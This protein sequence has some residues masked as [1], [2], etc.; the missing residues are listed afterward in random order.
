LALLNEAATQIAAGQSRAAF[1][2]GVHALKT[3]RAA[4][5]ARVSLP[6]CC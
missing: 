3:L 4:M 2:G 6:W 1:V 5:K